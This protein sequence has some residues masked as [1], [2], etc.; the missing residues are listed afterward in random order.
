MNI[1]EICKDAERIGISGHIRPDGDCAGS[2]LG[3]SLYLKKL[4]PEKEVKVFLEKPADIFSCI[5]GFSEIVVLEEG[6]PKVEPF[7]VYFALDARKDRLGAAEKF[8]E[9][10]ETTVNIDHHVSNAEGCGTYN[11]VYP[12]A[13]STCELVYELVEEEMLDADIAAALYIGIVHDTGV[14]RY[15]C[16]S[17][18]TMQAAAK[19]IGT[20]IDF[21]KLIEETFYEKTYVQNQIMGRALLESMLIMDG[22]CIVSYIDK[23][24][25]DFYQVTSKDF[26]GI[27]SQIK[28]TKG[29]DCAV[30]MYEIRTLEYKVSLRSTDKV[31]VAKVAEMFGGGGHVR[32]AGCTMNGTFHDVINNL[33]VHIEEQLE[34]AGA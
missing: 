4:F 14:F 23:K 15:S 9:E 2:C 30:F 31:N 11:Y 19:L 5:K 22:R 13:S 21:P 18:K 24:T 8:F 1:R 3:L 26:E 20:G 17:P 7:D 16:T 34:G 32:A 6:M 29:T 12:E 28:L 27:V 33:T 10:A 25:M